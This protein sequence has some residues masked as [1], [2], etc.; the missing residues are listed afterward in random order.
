MKA[1]ATAGKFAVLNDD[2]DNA[3]LAGALKP[4]EDI[5]EE[6]RESRAAALKNERINFALVG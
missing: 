6:P 2:A 1:D 5:L 3:D 4:L